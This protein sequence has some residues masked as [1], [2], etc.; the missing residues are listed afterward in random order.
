MRT[1]VASV[2]NIDQQFALMRFVT[3]RSGFFAAKN[4]SILTRRLVP[5][6]PLSWP[7]PICSGCLNY[8]YRRAQ[9]R[10]QNPSIVHYC[11]RSFFG[12]NKSV[13]PMW[14]L[15]RLSHQPASAYFTQNH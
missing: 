6:G 11:T 9:F 4:C 3:I 2:G 7:K 13:P 12:G 15:D 10:L 1:L 5:P 14:E 8:G